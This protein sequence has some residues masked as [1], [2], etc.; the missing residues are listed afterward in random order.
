L[1]SKIGANIFIAVTKG[2]AEE[3]LKGQYKDKQEI[4]IYLTELLT[5]KT[6]T[7]FSPFTTLRDFI[8]RSTDEVSDPS[9]PY[10]EKVNEN[11]IKITK[12]ALFENDKMVDA[13]NPEESKLVEAMKKRKKLPDLSVMIPPSAG[14]KEKNDEM[15]ILKFVGTKYHTKVNGDL[16]NPE[17]FVYM[18]ISGSIVDYDGERKL[19]D[20]E[21]RKEV[22]KR[23]GEHLEDKIIM[24]V[25][26]FQKLGIDPVGFGDPFRIRMP[27][28]GQKT[29]GSSRLSML[30]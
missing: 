2:T 27:K 16:N 29:V 10:L 24:T 25:M 28:I 4:N 3:L 14:S 18:Y 11:S 23:P 21:T 19:D 30:K 26:K 6:L 1:Y 7:A 22:E 8:Y 12:V 20:L 9:V 17:I 13:L 15:L 5:P